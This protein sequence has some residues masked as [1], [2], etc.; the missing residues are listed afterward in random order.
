M[1]TTV[2]NKMGRW[3]GRRQ[4]AGIFAS[5]CQS[6]KR[7][8][9]FTRMT[10]AFAVTLALTGA[11]YTTDAVAYDYGQYARE[12]TDVLIHD[13]PGR[14]RGTASF[15]G[16]TNWMQ[17]Q[18]STG[19]QTSIQSFTWAGNRTSKNVIASAAGTTG[20]YVV[21][22]AHY[23]TVMN[24]PT[25]QGLDDNA[26]GAGVL[27]EI[28]RNMAGIQLENGLEVVGFGAEEEGL[29]GSR[30]YV[31]ALDAEQRANMLGMINIDS[32]ITGDKMYAHAG[33]NIETN[34]ALASYRT[35]IFRIAEELNIPLFTNPG[36]NAAYPA[37]TGCCS[38]GESFLG[39]GIPVLFIES[40]NWDLGDLDGYTQ[41]DNPA[42]P[43]GST[44][45][46][47][48]E[49][50][51]TVLTGA[52]GE[53]R[54]EQRL[55]DYSRL[56]TRMV[57][58]ITN[59]DLLASTASGG[60]LIRQMS[61]QL[62]RQHDAVMNLH[63]RRWLSLLE[64]E[65]AVGT[66]KGEASLEGE[67]YPSSGFDL[68]GVSDANRVGINLLGDYKYSDSWT[69]GGSVG[70]QRSR[71]KL[72][73]DGSIEGDNWR[74]GLYALFQD[75]ASNWLAGDVNIGRTSFD[76]IR[77]IFLESQGGPVLLDQNLSS[78]TKALSWG[79]RVEGGHDFT[80][81]G[82]KSGPV[83]GLDYMRYRIDSFS[84]D[85]DF[86]T[87]LDY[88][89]QTYDSLEGSI[90]WRLHGTVAFSNGMVLRPYTSV[91][92]VHEFADG[93]PESV[94][95]ISQADGGVRT[96]DL[97]DVDKNFGRVQL[98][99]QLAVTEQVGVFSEINARLGHTDGSQVGYSLGLQFRF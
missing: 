41:T 55:S 1:G 63:S 97:G 47:P 38:D 30:A 48:N 60:A 12:T 23:D 94:A 56:L 29:R 33:D 25:L 6:L 28:A 72:S 68:P 3:S 74:A 88:G 71:D 8:S 22:G 69:F 78:D 7:S 54:I 11:S 65:R 34:P 44:W 66:F 49:D 35:Q 10:G 45:H 9:A 39:L 16:A 79:A 84:D 24:R 98:G 52:F 83:A 18:L 26:S 81:G 58:E 42:I 36:L 59:A 92:F 75:N 51:E 95:L 5:Y 86:R 46:D 57:L 91:K 32:L 17:S 87:G 21:V 73:H 2:I 50:N 93:R 67:L 90:G 85:T 82:V 14:Y 40:T 37:G 31:A 61:D 80:L 77:S 96:A 15:E 70:F 19:Y 89:K 13:F 76:N 27:T 64:T 62:G 99:A 20:K 4:T 53:E 43:G